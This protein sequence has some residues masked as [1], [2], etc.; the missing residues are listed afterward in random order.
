MVELAREQIPRLRLALRNLDRSTTE[1]DGQLRQRLQGGE[2]PAG[3]RVKPE[4]RARKASSGG[5]PM[6]L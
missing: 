5:W 6:A 3:G 2:K 4:R 1:Q